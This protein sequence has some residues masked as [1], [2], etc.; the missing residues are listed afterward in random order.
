MAVFRER[1]RGAP[2]VVA[3]GGIVLVV[4]AIIVALLVR[5]TAPP[6]D[7]LAG[8]RAKAL[9]AAQG[10]ELVTIEYP[11]MLRGETSG[12]QGALQRARAAFAAAR[13]PLAQIDAPA[14]DRIATALTT[15]DAQ[16]AAHAPL[17]EVTALANTTREQLMALSMP[18]KQ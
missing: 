4:G 5:S 13:D 6:R 11:K 3:A 16:V 14:V 2:L 7:P 12:A 10:L 15:L 17:A 18:R 8:A 9:E 1:R